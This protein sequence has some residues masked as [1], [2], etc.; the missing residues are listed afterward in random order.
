M[1][2][3]ILSKIRNRLKKQLEDKKIIDII[4]FGSI[5]KGKSNPSDIDIAVIS[6]ENPKINLKEFHISYLKPIDFIKNPPTIVTTLLR[7]GYSLKNKKF[8]SENLRFENRVLFS[9]NL[10]EL[11]PS[12][13]VQIVNFLRGKNK[14]KGLIEENGGNWIANQVFIIPIENENLIEKFLLNSN[15]HFKK[16]FVLIH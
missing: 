13:K 1:N 14:N 12:K 11:P 2:S 10:T 16:S 4:L 9:Y 3:E 15:V 5:V 8:L 6:E 7:E